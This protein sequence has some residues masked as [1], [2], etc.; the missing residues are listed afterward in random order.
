M[1][2]HF[3]AQARPVPPKEPTSYNCRLRW[4]FKKLEPSLA[5]SQCSQLHRVE[6]HTL[7]QVWL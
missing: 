1:F 5:Q 4:P 3:L 7:E 2:P 6:P